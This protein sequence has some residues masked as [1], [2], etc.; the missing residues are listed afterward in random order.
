MILN[1][2][3]FKELFKTQLVVLLILLRVFLSQSVIRLASQA[4]IGSIPVN[5]VAYL[6]I[7][8]LPDISV[9]MLPLTLFIAILLT[10]G[11]ICSDSEMVVIRS[12]GISPYKILA[13]VLVLAVITAIFSGICSNY[14]SSK[15]AVE[16]SALLY[17]AQTSPE[18]LPLESGRF[19]SFGAFN[20]YVENVSTNKEGQTIQNVYVMTLP[21]DASLGSV[22]V[23]QKGYLKTDEKGIQ[24]LYLENG[25]RYEGPLKTD[26]SFRVAEFDRLRAPVAVDSNAQ[27]TNADLMEKSTLELIQSDNLYANVE[28]Q[29]RISVIFAC[30]V[31]S[32]IAVPLSMV[33]PRQG[34]Y[35]RLVP[36]ILLYASYYLLLLS[37]RNMVLSGTIPLYPGI[38]IVPI[39]FF[40][41]VA[42]PLNL[43]AHIFIK[44]KKVKN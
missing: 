16:R 1:K 25:K 35:T 24:W 43:P 2:Y 38:Y 17:K 7:L 19:V 22:T 29:W 28:A 5:I 34:R 32:L 27:N 12:F 41:F 15:A 39:V 14:L 26:G 30:I 33:N 18:Y 4:V 37:M 36:A 23:S 11:R 3:I 6:A 31:L 20:I 13:I 9:I 10:L 21:E 42:I 44:I 40:I 8:S